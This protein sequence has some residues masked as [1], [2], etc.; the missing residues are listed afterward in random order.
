M[1]AAALTAFARAGYFGANT[2]EIAHDAGISQAYL[3]RLYRNKEELFVACIEAAKQKFV[4]QVNTI[5]AQAPGGESVGQ[6]LRRAAVTPV[7]GHAAE[8][9]SLMLHAVA[10]AHIEPIGSAV[11]ECYRSQF[12]R[13]IGLGASEHDVRAYLAWSQYANAMRAAGL[14]AASADARDR[15]LIPALRDNGS[16]D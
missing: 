9:A 14:D 7:P 3:Y 12:D 10:A 15:S 13:L 8:A 5:V 16:T 6:A 1:V 2:T 11:R 4:D